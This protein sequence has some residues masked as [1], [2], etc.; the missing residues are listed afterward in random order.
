M[1]SKDRGDDGIGLAKSRI[2]LELEHCQILDLDIQIFG[3]G[4]PS[5]GSGR[6]NPRVGRPNSRFGWPI[7]GFGGPNLD[8]GDQVQDLTSKSKIWMSYPGSGILNHGFDVQIR[9]LDFQIQDVHS[10]CRI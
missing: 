5:P 10:K 9:D 3:S 4:Q 1:V 8:V 2:G 7:S 6:P